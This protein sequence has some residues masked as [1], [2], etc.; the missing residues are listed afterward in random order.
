MQGEQGP[1]GIGL[2]TLTDVN[3]TLGDTTVEYDS[4]D[5]IQ[6]TSTGR[7]TYESGNKDATIDLDI[8]IKGGNGITIDKAAS[9]EMVEVKVDNN[10]FII[11]DTAG[12]TN[13]QTIE[14]NTSDDTGFISV[15]YNSSMV[16]CK[17][18][19]SGIILVNPG[20]TYYGLTSG[21]VKTLFGNQSIY[22]SG[23]IDLYRHT[24][25]VTITG[26]TITF[27]EISSN[28]LNIDSLTDLKTVFGDSFNFGARGSVRGSLVDCVTADGYYSWNLG[29][30]VGVWERQNSSWA[31]ESS[32][33]EFTITDDVKTV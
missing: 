10:G 25:T 22:G 33:G 20:G 30:E 5:G 4:T 16:Y 28:N 11:G 15:N 32:F 26:G 24:V 18:T 31:T 2:N 6:I 19:P 12:T 3:L 14:L 9:G 27:S 13:Y 17:V 7:F 1:P 21:N 8:P 23:N 29:S